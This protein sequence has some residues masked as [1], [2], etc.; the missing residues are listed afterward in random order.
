MFEDLIGNSESYYSRRVLEH[1]P[2]PAGVDWNSSDSQRLRFEQ[3]LRICHG[4]PEFSINDYGCGYG[5]L[6]NVLR[7]D[8]RLREYRGY[9][10]SEPMIRQAHQAHDAGRAVFFSDRRLLAPLDYTVAS[11]VFNVKQDASAERWRDYVL[12]ALDE[13]NALSRKGFSF[14]MLTSYSD[15]EKMRGDL[16]Y[17]DP[18][19]FF[20]Y[21]KRRFSREVYLLH[22]YGLFEFTIGVRKK[23]AA[24]GGAA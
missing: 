15:P 12:S 4:E 23:P 11:G 16:Y 2:T 19:F 18:C 24:A 22:D 21:S 7:E 13:L 9:D 1:G 5:A 8:P 14:N 17:G 20:D 6:L 10:V 3:L